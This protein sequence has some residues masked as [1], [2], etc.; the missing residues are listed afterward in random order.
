[1]HF[2]S[3]ILNQPSTSSCL[4]W[5]THRVHLLVKNIINHFEPNEIHAAPNMTAL[6]A[7]GC[8]VFMDRKVGG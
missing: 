4:P 1:M 5:F 7:G 6:S 2:L 3:Q 8:M